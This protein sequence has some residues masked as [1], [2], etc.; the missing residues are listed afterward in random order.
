M[1]RKTI[2]KNFP[3]QKDALETRLAT[4]IMSLSGLFSFLF[5]CFATCMANMPSNIFISN[6]FIKES[7]RKKCIVRNL[8]WNSEKPSSH[9]EVFWKISKNSSE[10]ACAG[11]SFLNKDADWRTATL[12]KVH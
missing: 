8:S 9:L 2:L 3:Q 6:A 7:Y 12:L 5:Y 1:V 4:K 11:V 10:N